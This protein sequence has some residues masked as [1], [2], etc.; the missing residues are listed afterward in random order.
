MSDSDL[1]LLLFGSQILCFIILLPL[2]L[3]LTVFT[4]KSFLDRFFR[5]PYFSPGELV[6]M[7]QSP[8][9]HMRTAIFVWGMVF[10]SLIRKRGIRE[11]RNHAPLLFRLC[12]YLMALSITSGMA[13]L[14]AMAIFALTL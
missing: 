7:S 12:A 5:E 6:V 10:P 14:I 9:R 11:I 13:S 1:F 4:P 8:G 3:G 2:W